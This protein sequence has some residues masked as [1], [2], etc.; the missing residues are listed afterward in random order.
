MVTIQ[1]DLNPKEDAK[2]K[3]LK[4]IFRVESKKEAIKKV[5]R[6]FPEEE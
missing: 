6:D 5:I 4:H 1:L 2:L 3:R